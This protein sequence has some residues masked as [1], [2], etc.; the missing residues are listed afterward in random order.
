MSIGYSLVKLFLKVK[1]EKKS[2]S[3]DPIDYLKKRKQDVHSPGSRVSGCVSQSKEI[4]SSIVTSLKPKGGSTS[5]FLLLYFHGGAFV[6]GPTKEN[7][8]FLAKIAKQ[9]HSEAWMIDYPKAPEHK[10]KEVTQN[11][12]LTYQE[13][14]KEY[15]PAKVILIGDS[16]GGNLILTLTQRL[17][18]EKI[19][20]PNRLIPISPLIDASLTNPK[21]KE[22][23]LLDL[24]LSV[25]GVSSAKKMLLDGLS[26]TDP[27][28]SPIFGS[29]KNFPPIHLFSAELD[30]FT[31]DQDLFVEKAKQEAV[32]IEVIYGKNMPHVW[33]IFPVMS[34]AKEGQMKIVS[35]INLAIQNEK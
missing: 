3:Q 6:Y 23:D 19:A 5:G 35:I 25:K 28:I 34:E 2:W 4:G 30:I 17:L 14:I 16:A 22:M 7:W 29:L 15:D 27:L 1:G 10:I 31:P 13:A 33:P 24:V 26:L 18:K 21:I 12:F 32:D 9:T 20:L 11:V 8:D